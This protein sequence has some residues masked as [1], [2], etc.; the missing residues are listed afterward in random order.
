[1]N[2]WLKHPTRS[3]T[4]S[5]LSNIKRPM[6]LTGTPEEVRATEALQ[7]TDYKK[8]DIV[9]IARGCNDL[10]SE[11]QEEL[12][13]VL[14]PSTSRYSKGNAENVKEHQSLSHS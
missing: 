10:S 7:P 12:L 1:M 2:R 9:Q 6:E 3:S 14:T 13:Q 4:P 5:S 8:A 11:Q